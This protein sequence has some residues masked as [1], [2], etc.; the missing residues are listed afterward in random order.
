MQHKNPPTLNDLKRV[1]KAQLEWYA[2]TNVAAQAGNRPTRTNR[3]QLT[4]FTYGRF[5]TH[6]APTSKIELN[7]N[8]CMDRIEP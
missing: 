8:P 5:A 2:G 7:R 1:F 6:D 4:R 3:S